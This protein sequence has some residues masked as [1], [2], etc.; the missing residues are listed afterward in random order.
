M[1]KN[2]ILTFNELL[3]LKHPITLPIEFRRILFLIKKD[4]I[5]EQKESLLDIHL[6]LHQR[7]IYLHYDFDEMYRRLRI[8]LDMSYPL[9]KPIFMIVTIP[10]TTMT[11]RLL[12]LHHH[13][14]QNIIYYV[15]EKCILLDFYLHDE[16]KRRTLQ[17]FFLTWNNNGSILIIYELFRSLHIF[18]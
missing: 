13:I 8:I 11:H 6:N 7:T 3:E 1:K 16:Q 2:I 15:P 9:S 10:Q 18:E 17:F 4:I 12:P 14:R 5:S